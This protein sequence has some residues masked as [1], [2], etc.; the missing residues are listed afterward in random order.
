MSNTAGGAISNQYTTNQ[1]TNGRRPKFERGGVEVAVPSPARSQID[2]SPAAERVFDALA[3]L[4]D[5]LADARALE[6]AAS[7]QL[8]QLMR[9]IERG[10]HC[11]AVETDDGPVIADLAHARIQI[12]GRIE[13]LGTL[14]RQA[15]DLIFLLQDAYAHSRHA[16]G[17]ALC[18]MALSRPIIA[19]TRARTCSFFCRSVARSLIIASWR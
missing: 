1:S 18:S 9:D 14:F 12:L 7:T 5:L 6:L 17:H 11:N 16:L 3:Q 10:D 15:C 4:P 2:L 8:E 13:Q 19:S